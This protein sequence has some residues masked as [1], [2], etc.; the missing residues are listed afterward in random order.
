MKVLQVSDHDLTSRRYNGYDLLDDLAS[1]GI[2]GRQAVLRKQSSDPR[3]LELLRD[4]EDRE[5]QAALLNVER[6]ASFDNVLFPWGRRLVSEPAFQ[7]ADVVHYHVIHHK[8]ISLADLPMLFSAKPSVWT[9]H[10]PWPITGHCVHPETCEGWL[11]GCT[12]CP[13]LDA[14][15]PMAEDKAGAMWQLK[16]EMF[17]RS[18]VDL[19]VSSRFMLDMVERAGILSDH[20]RVQLIPFGLDLD[21]FRPTDRSEARKRLGIPQDDAVILLRASE[22]SVKGLP[23]LREAMLSSPATR[24]T[25]LL[26]V[27]SAGLL[28]DLRDRYTIKDLG[29]VTDQS[30]M[31]S[32]YAAC[33][34][35]VMP[36]TAESF[37][38][39]AVE[40]MACARPVV[41]FAGTTVED[42]TFAPDVGLAVPFGD[43]RAL[44]AGI[45]AL[46]ENPA[47]AERRGALGRKIAEREYGQERYL[48]QLAAL[49]TA[50]AHKVRG[51]S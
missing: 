43:A 13:H 34:A 10:D 45:D 40:A 20:V 33:D 41:C 46:L 25:T 12:P 19:V 47:E 38:M 27:G 35:F 39:M 36:S 26:T 49:Y 5:L 16:R 6:R 51:L 29:T 17:E 3:V 1:R 37:G 48:D 8:M 42:I 22:W 23:H 2:E 18:D 44:R 50:V 9:F 4:D 31:V 7:E 14:L 21:T 30:T 11:T 28:H 32:A 24:R 15:F